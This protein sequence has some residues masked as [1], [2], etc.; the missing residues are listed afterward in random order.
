VGE[1]QFDIILANI[2]RNVILAHLPE[3]DSIL[4]SN[5]YLLLS[6]MISD[7]RF[8]I[9]EELSIKGFSVI[10]EAEKDQWIQVT[11]SKL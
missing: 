2:N 4:K 7:D 10:R 1:K 5:G 11:A 3:L 8:R 6:G 9:K